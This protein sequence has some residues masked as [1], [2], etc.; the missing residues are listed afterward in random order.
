MEGE[1]A[2]K[3]VSLEAEEPDDTQQ[4]PPAHHRSSHK[5][6]KS[7]QHQPP[8]SS[9]ITNIPSTAVLQNS[10]QKTSAPPLSTS[11]QLPAAP[12]S[13]VHSSTRG[14]LF[15][16]TSGETSQNST[17]CSVVGKVPESGENTQPRLMYIN[18]RFGSSRPASSA[19]LLA[20][21]GSNKASKSRK[22]QR[23][24]EGID[25]LLYNRYFFHPAYY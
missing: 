8:S 19:N 6:L 17:N 21:H 16:T 20:S 12:V 23:G 10:V 4:K 3:L 1:E 7:S 25:V 22:M 11:N 5:Q 2:E 24:K 15:S 13:P 9:L 14:F 18:E